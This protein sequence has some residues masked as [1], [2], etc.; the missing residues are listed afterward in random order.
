MLLRSFYILCLVLLSMTSHALQ[1]DHSFWTMINKQGQFKDSDLHYYI[2]MQFRFQDEQ[3]N[4]RSTLIEG[5]LGKSCLLNDTTCWM[6]YRYTLNRPFHGF[7]PGNQIFSHLIIVRRSP[8]LNKTLRLRVEARERRDESELYFQ[9]RLR[10]TLSLLSL[11]R[12]NIRPLAYDEIFIPLNSTS[13]TSSRGINENRFFIGFDYI[14]NKTSWIEIG[15]INQFNFKRPGE[16]ENSMNHII[17][18]T[19]NF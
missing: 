4:W 18:V 6:G 19:Y 14:L 17:T 12:Q 7:Y 2:F 8:S 5:G 15:Y 13:Y 10:G 1:Q 16:S 11:Q 3:P 9:L